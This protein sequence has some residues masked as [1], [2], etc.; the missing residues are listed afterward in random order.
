MPHGEK[1]DTCDLCEAA[2]IT[3]WFHEDD[4]CWIA[5]PEG[6]RL[7]LVEVPPDHPIRRRVD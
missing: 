4:E 2:R 5:D 1:S 6:T 3:H 7:C